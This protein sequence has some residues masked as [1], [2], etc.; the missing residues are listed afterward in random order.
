MSTYHWSAESTKVLIESGLTPC[1]R[2]KGRTGR[3]GL[4]CATFVHKA[5][6]PL[7]PNARL[8]RKV[9]GIARELGAGRIQAGRTARS[10]RSRAAHL[11]Q[12]F[13]ATLLAN[14]GFRLGPHRRA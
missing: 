14:A 13:F 3:N 1:P 6:L 10:R 9:P 7:G 8:C 5:K 12:V 11:D 2:G 4:R